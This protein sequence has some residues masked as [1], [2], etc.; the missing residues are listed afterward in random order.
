MGSRTRQYQMFIKVALWPH[1][2]SR[3]VLC[4]SCHSGTSSRP[5]GRCGWGSQALGRREFAH[6]TL[7]RRHHVL[8]TLQKALRSPSSKHRS[9]GRQK[10]SSLADE[11]QRL[12]V[13][14]LSS[15]SS[16]GSAHALN[17]RGLELP[18]PMPGR[19]SAGSLR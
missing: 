12:C 10:G 14:L 1:T 15:L 8:Y 16:T 17:P 13:L 11:S 9:C 3:N 5:F 4:N 7:G 2:L 6:K 18:K 19:L